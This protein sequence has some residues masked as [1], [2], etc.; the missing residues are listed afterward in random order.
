MSLA[1]HVTATEGVDREHI[2][3]D[4]EEQSEATWR[5]LS[6]DA[7]APV[8]NVFPDQEPV[9]NIAAYKVS[10]ARRVGE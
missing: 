9:R 1:Q 2:L 5:R 4:E 10:N 8:D 3:G 6:F 7:F